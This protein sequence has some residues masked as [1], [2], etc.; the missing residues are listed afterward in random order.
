AAELLLRADWDLDRHRTAFEARPDLLDAGPEVRADAVHLVDEAQTR[1][2]VA[3][4]LAPDR[5][6]LR[7]D[8]RH[9]VEHR[10]RAVEDAQRALDLGREVDVTRRVDDVDRVEVPLA[11]RRRRLDRDAALPLLLEEVHRRVAVVDLPRLVD[12][13]GQE[14]DALGDRRLAG[15]DVRHDADVAV[16]LE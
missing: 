2:A 4:R 8:A 5:L 7:F 1:N 12:L 15:I 10:D 13:P 9:R 6:R 3:V 11:R 16:G 14:E